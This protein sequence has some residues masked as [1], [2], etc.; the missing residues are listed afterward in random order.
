MMLE[1]LNLGL[2]IFFLFSQ[3]LKKMHLIKFW[4]FVVIIKPLQQHLNRPE[5]LLSKKNIIE[6]LWTVLNSIGFQI[7]LLHLLLFLLQLLLHTMIIFL[8]IWLGNW[9]SYLISLSLVDM[10]D[11]KTIP[12]PAAAPLSFAQLTAQ[13]AA[14]QPV[15]LICYLYPK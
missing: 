11:L 3:F 14:L 7:D 1:W 8:L 2:F 4:Y 6:V 15:C 12:A 13:Y 5:Q 10:G 9:L